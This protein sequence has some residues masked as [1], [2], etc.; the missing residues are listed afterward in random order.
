MKHLFPFDNAL[1]RKNS[2]RDQCIQARC[3]LC[4]R[5]ARIVEIPG[6]ELALAF[7]ISFGCV[8]QRRET[9]AVK[10]VADLASFAGTRLFSLFY[11]RCDPSDEAKL[12]LI[13]V[14]L[15]MIEN[16]L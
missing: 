3:T 1:R 7:A 13:N 5:A 16:W 14:K 6:P 11:Q 2:F 9:G 8:E 4:C 12:H 15:L 10:L